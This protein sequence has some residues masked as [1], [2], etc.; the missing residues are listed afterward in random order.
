MK[1]HVN[2]LRAK[3]SAAETG[4]VL[5]H[6]IA[7][8]RISSAALREKPDLGKEK[9]TWLQRHDQD[10]GSLY[11]VLPL[12]MG[13]PVAA[14]DHLDR[15]RGIL[16]GCAGEVVGWVWPADA[17]GGASQEVT[18]IWNEL[19]ACIM[20]R[21][22]T[23][24]KTTWRVQGIDEDN[25]FPVVPRC[26]KRNRGISTRAGSVSRGSSFHWPQGLPPLPTPPKDKLAQKVLS[27][28]CTLARQETH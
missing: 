26:L 16:R 9:L 15:G 12:C 14:A 21:F 4:Q 28:T 7:K 11:G 27:W 3:A 22:K 8:G 18:Q 13:M 20:V 24:T 10:C 25:V 23:K 5:R 2:K 19:P 1:Y 6:A 17:V